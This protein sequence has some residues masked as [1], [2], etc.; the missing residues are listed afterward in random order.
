MNTEPHVYLVAYDIADP[1]RLRKVYKLMRGFGDHMQYSVF[2]CVLSP[3]QRERMAD[4]LHQTIH[5]AE[6]Q[7]LIVPLGKASAKRSWR[8]STIGIP[9]VHPERSVKVF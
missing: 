5:H 7:V 8:M 1:K 4:L 3:M 2:C 6:D 9:L